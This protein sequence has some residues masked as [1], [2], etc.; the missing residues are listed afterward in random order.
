MHLEALNLLQTVREEDELQP[1]GAYLE[2]WA[3]HLRAEALLEDPGLRAA[4]PGN[5]TGAAN[6]EDAEEEGPELALLS[7]DECF[8]EALR[9]LSECE[10]LVEQVGY[11]DEGIAEHAQELLKGLKERGVVL[12]PDE[13]AGGEG[14]EVGW[15]DMDEEEEVEAEEAGDGDVAMS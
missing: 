12:P 6:G 2:G 13:E 4:T 14:E 5:G 10:M 15:E 11:P 1:E 7:A 3:Y 8:A 9:S